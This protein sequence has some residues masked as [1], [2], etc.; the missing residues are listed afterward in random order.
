MDLLLRANEVI[1]YLYKQLKRRRIN[2]HDDCAILS[3]PKNASHL[4]LNMTTQAHARAI[5][6][7]A[8]L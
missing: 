6:V 3:F 4:P 7:Q 1:V 5:Y 8:L 2:L